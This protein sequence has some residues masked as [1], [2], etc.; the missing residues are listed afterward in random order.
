MYLNCFKYSFLRAVDLQAP[1]LRSFRIKYGR[2]Q[3]QFLDNNRNN[4]IDAKASLKQPIN[5]IRLLWLHVKPGRVS[6]WDVENH[7]ATSLIEWKSHPEAL[8]VITHGQQA[9]FWETLYPCAEL[10]PAYSTPQANKRGGDDL[11]I[12]RFNV[13]KFRTGKISLPFRAVDKQ[14]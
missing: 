2:V 4:H 6:K 5:Q 12:I 14:S 11:W 8:R 3:E 7:F 1:I 10:Q 9:A 13:Q